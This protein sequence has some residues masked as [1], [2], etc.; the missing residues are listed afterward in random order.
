MIKT[1][2][3]IAPGNSGGAALNAQYKLVGVPSWVRLSQEAIAKMAYVRPIN[4]A[5]PLLRETIPGW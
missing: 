4:D 1:D 5:L 2:T 3:Q